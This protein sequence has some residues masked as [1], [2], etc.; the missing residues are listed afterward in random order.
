[1]DKSRQ[2]SHTESKTNLK[3]YPYFTR[4]YKFDCKKYF[5]NDLLL[6]HAGNSTNNKI[7]IKEF[8][9]PKYTLE[10]SIKVRE[11]NFIR[12]S[13]NNKLRNN[14]ISKLSTLLYSNKNNQNTRN[15]ITIRK[16][17]NKSL[18]A[19][20]EN[21]VEY[22]TLPKLNEEKSYLITESNNTDFYNLNLDKETFPKAKFLYEKLQSNK[23]LI[24]LKKPLRINIFRT[25]DSK[26]IDCPRVVTRPRLPKIKIEKNGNDLCDLEF[27]QKFKENKERL[28][29]IKSKRSLIMRSFDLFHYDDKKWKKFSENLTNKNNYVRYA[30]S[31]INNKNEQK[32]NE[33]GN[34]IKTLFN[35]SDESRKL[36]LKNEN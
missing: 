17:L 3:H 11:I 27:I 20:D 7:K 29:K 13:F 18:F 30:I 8:S 21:N 10:E 15:Y 35:S 12:K 33:L 31:E 26:T 19:L 22:L 4:N 16:N 5:L 14:Y 6:R 1:M 32:L 23:N 9:L 34:E 24:R 25:K 36:K 28:E 2:Y